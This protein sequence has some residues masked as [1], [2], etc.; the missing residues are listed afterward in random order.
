MGKVDRDAIQQFYDEYGD[1]EVTR[2]VETVRGR[3][4]FE[5][6]RRFLE[7]FIQPGYRVLEI[8]SGPGRFTQILAELGATV[9]V[10]DLSPVQ[11]ELN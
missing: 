5:I 2:L 7:R 3:V 9:T 11:L 1:R 8:G 4:S 10:T 6:H